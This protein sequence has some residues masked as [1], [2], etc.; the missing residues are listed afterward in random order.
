MQNHIEQCQQHNIKRELI[1]KTRKT[2]QSKTKKN[3]SAARRGS[4]TNAKIHEENRV[5]QTSADRPIT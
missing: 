4:S 2:Q 3:L 5:T 1:A